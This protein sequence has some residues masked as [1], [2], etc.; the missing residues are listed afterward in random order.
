METLAFTVEILIE[1]PIEKIK[2]WCIEIYAGTDSKTRKAQWEV[3][4]KRKRI[5]GDN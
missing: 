1:N 4:G 3:I 2:W 5:W